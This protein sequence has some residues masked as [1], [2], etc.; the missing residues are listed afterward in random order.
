MMSNKYYK[1][2]VDILPFFFTFP[3]H[4]FDY[5]STNKYES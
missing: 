3:Y 4:D 1:R 2:T 5:I